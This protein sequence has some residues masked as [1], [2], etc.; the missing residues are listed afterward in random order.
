MF[1]IQVNKQGKQ[2]FSIKPSTIKYLETSR[3]VAFTADLLLDGVKVGS[4]ENTGQGGATFPRI[5]GG[6]G[7]VT[8]KRLEEA[9]KPS[10]G[11]EWYLEELMNVA[12][13]INS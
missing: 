7:G 6:W 11:V 4:I 10:D 5:D 13:Q 1:S 2:M 9:A 3:G 12:E 8:M